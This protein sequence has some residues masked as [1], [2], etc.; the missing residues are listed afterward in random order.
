MIRIAILL[1]SLCVPRANASDDV[2]T[3][4]IASWNL[5][6]LAEAGALQAAN[7]WRA[8]ASRGWSGERIRADLP[9]CDAYRKEGIA[10][11]A[12]YRARKLGALRSGLAQIARRGVD[13]LAIQ[14]VRSPAALEAVLPPLFR[15]AC[16]TAR[17]DAQNLAIA[18]R[19]GSRLGE[20]CREVRALALERA[21]DG[22]ALRRGLELRFTVAG[23]QVTLLNVHLK[24]RC[25]T[26]PLDTPGDAHCAA[27]QRQVAALEGW[28]ERQP[29]PF[30]IVGDWNRD[31]ENEARMNDGARSDRSDPAAPPGDPRVIR[32]LFA[33]INDGVPASS[34]MEVVKVD[35]SAARANGCHAILD[36]LV[37]SHSL[38]AA[39]ARRGPPRARL[40]AG[41]A[42]GS[43]HC[44][45]ETALHLKGAGP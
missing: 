45:L 7:Y 35:R 23:V 27:L 15:V 25:A 11:S 37:V 10:T 20:Q 29:G 4:G 41:A 21:G 18:V 3:L 12:Q 38:V 2:R 28:V 16:F 39:L 24:A 30:L 14:E 44:S 19:R 13:I 22:G 8:C 34:L 9:P 6:W 31:L 17:R 33:E 43:D 5:A 40:V 42:G 36:Q 32:N 1:F 26:A